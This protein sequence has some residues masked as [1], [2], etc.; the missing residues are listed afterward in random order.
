MITMPETKHK[1]F[2]VKHTTKLGTARYIPAV[3][4]KIPYSLQETVEG[5]AAQGL[6]RVYAEEVRFV[7]GVPYPVKKPA[8]EAAAR[9]S[10]APVS[11]AGDTSVPAVPSAKRGRAG[12]KPGKG[13]VTQQAAREFE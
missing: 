3:C 6:A 2:S 12:G 5:M 13:S 7:T 8:A 11:H 4:Y 9:P 10:S 1:F